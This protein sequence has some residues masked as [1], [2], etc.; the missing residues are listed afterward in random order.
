MGVLTRCLSGSP[1]L[2]YGKRLVLWDWDMGLGQVEFCIDLPAR[3]LCVRNYLSVDYH[4][5][6]CNTFALS[7]VRKE[8]LM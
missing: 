3:S 7:P 4:L 5:L 8:L 2:S 1:A 6:E